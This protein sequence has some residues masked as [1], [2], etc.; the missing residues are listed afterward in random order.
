[1]ET[2]IAI[3]LGAFLALIGVICYVRVS[4]DFKEGEKK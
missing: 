3:L 1:M 4:K 2:L